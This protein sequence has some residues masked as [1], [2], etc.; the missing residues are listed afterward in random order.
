MSVTLQKKRRSP[1]AKRG[2]SGY[3]TQTKSPALRGFFIYSRPDESVTPHLP[4]R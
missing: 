4:I 3:I 1:A 2:D